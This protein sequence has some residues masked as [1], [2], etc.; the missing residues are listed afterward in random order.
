MVGDILETG[1]V[2]EGEIMARVW[3]NE[4]RLAV[5]QGFEF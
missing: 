4:K 1:R 2:S 5:R 3:F